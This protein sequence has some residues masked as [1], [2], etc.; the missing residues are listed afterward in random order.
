[1][2]RRILMFIYALVWQKHRPPEGSYK[3]DIYLSYNIKDLAFVR[4]V[5]LESLENTH[6]M[7]CCVPDRDFPG[8]GFRNDI[9]IEH[10]LKSR[11]LIFLITEKSLKSHAFHLESETANSFESY[12]L[13][14]PLIIYILKEIKDREVDAKFL[15]RHNSVYKWPACSDPKILDRE[16]RRVIEKIV[17]KVMDQYVKGR[18]KTNDQIE[19]TSLDNGIE[20]A[21]DI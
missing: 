1:M 6:G 16:E 12:M 14:P 5:L 11:V 2:I 18:D 8:I 20:G 17:S 19:L 7:K 21:V 3:Y 10:M 13:Y 15:I 4:R 9:A